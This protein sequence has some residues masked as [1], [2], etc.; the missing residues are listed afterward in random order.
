MPSAID[1]S[2]R[3]TGSAAEV[4]SREVKVHPQPVAEEERI[5]SL[6]VVRGFALLGILLMNIQDFSMPGAAYFNPTVYGDLH[7][8]NYWVWYL[9]HVLA[10][11]KFM[12]VFSML[13]GAG[14]LLMTSRVEAT[15]RSPAALHYRRMGWLVLFGL[16]H[17]YLLW[18]GDILYDYAVCGLLI[19]L[20]RKR[21]PR[22][23]L[24]LGL[25]FLAV[26]PALM[27]FM[28]WSV[29]YWPP[30]QVQSVREGLW[31]PTPAMITEEI[32]I[33][34]GGWLTQMAARVPDTIQMQTIYFLLWTFWR[35]LG[36]ML[37]GMGLFKLGVFS[38]KRP[39][40]LYW[41]LIAIGACVGVP[42]IAYGTHRDIATGW[43]FR[44]SFFFGMEY[45]YWGSILVALGW[46]GL[47]MLAA[48]APALAAITRRLAAVGRMAF[49]NYILHTVMCTTIF[50]GHGFGLF[51]KIDR[52]WQ[53][54]IVLG[55]WAP[56]MLISPIWLRHF[57]F[58][59]L[60]W[61]WRSLTY[62]RWEPF[63]RR[64]QGSP[65]AP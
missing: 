54:V 10:D 60:E 43:D 5:F 39:A 47:M 9:S 65:V 52:I 13:F 42:I 8:A 46:V 59:P 33:Y 56:Q 45:N 23:L 16:L 44:K 48:Q 37:I 32:A 3:A 53:F 49:T 38:G 21:E 7:G 63:R 27:L 57:S 29:P 17:G 14:V 24:V 62:L 58:G 31:M 2:V 41:W 50:Y 55:V 64:D 20:F 11:E 12:A 34:R 25:L 36:L 1:E 15:G 4:A 19:F 26:T 51:G 61:L 28:G 18:D 22:T 40:K 35:V 30:D 6:D